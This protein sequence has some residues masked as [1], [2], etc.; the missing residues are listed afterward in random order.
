M[1]ILSNQPTISVNMDNLLG[2]G[3]ESMVF[4]KI[5]ENEEKALK[6]APYETI[7]TPQITIFQNAMKK[8]K[9]AQ[10]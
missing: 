9:A 8:I 7:S 3:G 1:G 10:S 4:K 6:M 5:I 2:I